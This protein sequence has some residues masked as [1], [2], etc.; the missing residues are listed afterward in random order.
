MDRRAA[1]RLLSASAAAVAIPDDLTDLGRALHARL[2]AG[3]TRRV[4]DRHQDEAVVA[5]SDLILPATDT[6]GAKAA[7]VN[8]FI[9]LLLAEWCEAP[10][11]D[12]FQ[13]GLAMVDERARAAFGK[14]FVA[15]TVAEQTALLTALDDEAAR[16]GASPTA[17]RGPE[18]FYRR[19]K[20]LTLFGYF[21][22]EIGAEQEQHFRIIPG[23]YVP[24]APAD[25]LA[26]SE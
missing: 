21:T 6:P 24:C 7:R 3:A 12:Q 5:L 19:L 26:G 11:C 20:W 13:A 16:W 22:S 10:E 17:T 2:G 9:D 18:P 4:L 25:T 1:L 14:D 23:R 8:E 15:G